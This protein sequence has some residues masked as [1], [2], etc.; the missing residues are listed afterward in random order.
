MT[1]WMAI[2]LFRNKSLTP[3]Q[4]IDRNLTIAIGNLIITFIIVMITIL[5][6][7]WI[8]FHK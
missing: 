7:L 5:M 6:R 8:L 1:Y 3:S 4:Q 2:K